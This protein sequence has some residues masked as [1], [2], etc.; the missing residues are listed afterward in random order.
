LDLVAALRK[1]LNM[2]ERGDFPEQVATPVGWSCQE[3]GEPIRE[4]DEGRITQWEGP[5]P[6]LV[7]YHRDCFDEAASMGIGG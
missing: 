5:A 7:A 6:K 2:A 4:G 3:C 1:S